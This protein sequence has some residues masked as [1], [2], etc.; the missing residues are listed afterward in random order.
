MSVRDRRVPVLLLADMR[1]REGG[2]HVV[3]PAS[4]RVMDRDRPGR[5]RFLGPVKVRYVPADEAGAIVNS[6]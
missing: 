1:L 3:L 4:A 6:E 2:P 5:Q